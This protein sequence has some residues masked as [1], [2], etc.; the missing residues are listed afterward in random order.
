MSIKFL[1]VI[2]NLW[3]RELKDLSKVTQPIHYLS[4]EQSQTL[5]FIQAFNLWAIIHKWKKIQN[6]LFRWKASFSFKKNQ[7]FLLIYL[8][9]ANDSVSKIQPSEYDTYIEF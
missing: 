6:I 2:G 5:I 4:Q 8:L 3:H 9:D 7:D 1:P